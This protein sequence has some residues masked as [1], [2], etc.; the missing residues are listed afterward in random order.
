[1]SATTLQAEEVSRLHNICN[2]LRYSAQMP[3][4]DFNDINDVTQW[5]ATYANKLSQTVD[6][7]V[8]EMGKYQLL[9]NDVAAF[10]RILGVKP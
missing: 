3:R 6:Q 4:P 9:Q 2:T 5:L 8:T 7:H 10:R 1:M